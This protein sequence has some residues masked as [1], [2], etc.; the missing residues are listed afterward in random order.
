MGF[1]PENEERKNMFK[2]MI[3]DS[4]QK[5]IKKTLTSSKPT[6]QLIQLE[7]LRLLF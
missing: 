5:K 7:F 6:I 4:L 3:K 1:S 2:K